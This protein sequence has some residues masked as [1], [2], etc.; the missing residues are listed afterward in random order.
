LALAVVEVLQECVET[1]LVLKEKFLEWLLDKTT[2][3]VVLVLV[4]RS[5][6]E[7]LLRLLDQ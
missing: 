5:L 2:T 1:S 6:H 3:M 7:M 4:E